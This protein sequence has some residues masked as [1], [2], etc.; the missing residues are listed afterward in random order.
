MGSLTRLI[1]KTLED[2][3]REFVPQAHYPSSASFKYSDGT[4]IGPDILSQ[5]L[6]HTGVKPSNPPDGPALLRMR[7]GDAAHVA[8]AD[9]LGK[10]NVKA[11]PESR[12]KMSVPGLRLPVSG[13][14]DNLIELGGELEVVE[15]KSSQ[16][17]AMFGKGWGIA[18]KGPKE[19]HILQVIAYLN[20]VPG[21]KRARFIYVARD[22]GGM[23]E[24][25]VDRSGDSYSVN[26]KPV[27]ELSWAGMVSR[28][29]MLESLVAAKT[30]PEPDYRPW[31]NKD[32]KIMSVK[33]I[34]G[35]SYKTPWRVSYDAYRD[36]VWGNPENFKYSENAMHGLKPGE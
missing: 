8:I 6:K 15:V 13:R 1:Y 20:C 21:L 32:G 19:D 2:T 23:L 17:N 14:V 25:I 26:G 29:A 34:K 7:M 9:A 12:F 30:A 27:R 31:L 3:N 18:D 4:V 24:F 28:W 11:C 35:V 36:Y 33:T 5:Y 16:D 10:A 22:N